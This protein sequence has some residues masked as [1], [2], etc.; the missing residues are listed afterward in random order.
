MPPKRRGFSSSEEEEDEDLAPRRGKDKKTTGGAKARE[1]R[2]VSVRNSPKKRRSEASALTADPLLEGTGKANDLS[3][4]EEEMDWANLNE[5]ELLNLQV[6]PLAE[7]CMSADGSGSRLMIKEIVTENF[8]SYYGRHTIGPFHTNYTAIIGPN[9]SG[10]S[11]V[12]DSLLFVFGF[13]ASKIRSKKLSVLIHNSAGHDNLQSCTVEVHFQK[14]VEESKDKYALV[15]QSQFAISRTAFRDNS[16]KYFITSHDGHRK[17]V[18]FKEV[19]DKLKEVG[20]DL[21]H[22]RFLILQGEVE[23]IAM[24]KPKADEKGN[25]G[26]LEYLEDIIGTS[27][28]KGPLQLLEKKIEQIN[29]KLTSQSRQLSLATKEKERLEGP[30]KEMIEIMKLE[31]KIALYTDQL[32]LKHRLACTRELKKLEE[33]D[34]VDVKNARDDVEAERKRVTEQQKEKKE[35][36]KDLEKEHTK[37]QATSDQLATD[38]NNLD[39]RDLKRKNDIKRLRS[40]V[41]KTKELLDKEN[42]RIEEI[43][44]IPEK[45]G[46]KIEQQREIIKEMHEQEKSAQERLDE[47]QKEYAERTVDDREE[48][49]KLEEAF[50]EANQKALDL[51]GEVEQLQVELKGMT[52]RAAKSTKQFESARAQYDELERKLDEKKGE[53]TAADVEFPDIERDLKEKRERAAELRKQEENM[54]R[55][56]SDLRGKIMDE[57]RKVNEV[58]GGSKLQQSLMAAK[59]SGKIPGIIGRLGDLGGIDEKYDIAA[60]TS[61]GAFDSILVEDVESSQKCF[62]LC[63]RE[64][65]G[66]INVIILEKIQNLH[67]MMNNMRQTPEN[68][69]RVFDLLKISDDRIRVAFYWAV[70]DTLVANDSEQAQRVAF[71]RQRHRVVSLQ[72]ALFE[73]SGT[74]SG[75]GQPMKGKLGKNVKVDTSRDSEKMLTEWRDELH[76]LEQRYQLV[77]DQIRLEETEVQNL[78]DRGKKLQDVIRKL[79]SEIRN[80]ETSLEMQ[81]KNLKSFERQMN[82]QKASI[83]TKKVAETED[84]ILK[85]TEE[86]KEAQK[87]ADEAKARVAKV[88]ERLQVVRRELLTLFED[89]ISEAKKKRQA[90]EKTLTKEQ[91]AI[92]TADHNMKKALTRKKE[93][94]GDLEGLC[95]Q[96]EGKEKETSDTSEELAELKEN[97]AKMEARLKEIDATLK[98]IRVG[99]QELDKEE[100]ELEK[101]MKEV[102]AAITQVKERMSHFKKQIRQ[103]DEQRGKLPTHDITSLS[104]DRSKMDVGEEEAEAKRRLLYDIDDDERIVQKEGGARVPELPGETEEEYL[105]RVAELEGLKD[106]RRRQVQKACEKQRSE[107]FDELEAREAEIRTRF[108]EESNSPLMTGKLPEYT[109]EEIDEFNEEELNFKLKT[110]EQKAHGGKSKLNLRMVDEYKEKV[111]RYEEELQRLDAIRALRNRHETKFVELTADRLTEFTKSFQKIKEYV[112]QMYQMLTIGGNAQ[113]EVKDVI[114]PF[115]HGVQYLVRPPKKSWKRIQNLSGGEKTLSSLALVFALHKFRPTPLYVMD[116]IDAALDFRNVSIIGHYVKEQTKNAQFIIISLRSNMFE[117]SDRLVGVCKVRDCS[118]NIVV[119]PAAVMAKVEPLQK[120]ICHLTNVRL[121]FD[122]NPNPAAKE[123]RSPLS[124]RPKLQ[125]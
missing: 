97:K 74:M 26:M 33:E 68:L 10:K 40:D 4:D 66:V 86:H 45:S 96:L 36:T 81:K 91:A 49:G 61:S 8:K 89:E 121:D 34:F 67:G 117:K 101:K 30:V 46:K 48:K 109:E 22:N 83:D 58:A 53:L 125:T 56:L 12:I 80:Y 106:E 104:I 108:N 3:D 92:N 11:N 69:P 78:I 43:E 113:I 94:E 122:N 19:A 102:T 115:E 5:E 120:A 28:F 20:I 32:A 123:P 17:T 87:F 118:R 71:G 37:L 85:F 2:E 47:N 13:K 79:K 18:T 62:E 29:E 27:R 23:Q 54:A 15:P 112:K 1:K 42:K 35:Q 14:I 114:R 25:E 9:G 44:G 103:R 72:G 98:E 51:R 90:A 41:Q 76:S 60:S 95:E 16:S 6:P 99:N 119:E 84:R 57:Q 70:R 39:Q 52:E 73:P 105:L 24:M 82:D 38:I 59:R 88:D 77:K 31:N 111:I 64:N 116:E 7:P 55:Q 100:N 124:K 50:G 65:L 110:V 107:L 21:K 63:R 75:G 93:I